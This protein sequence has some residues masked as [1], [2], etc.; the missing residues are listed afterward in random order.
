[1]QEADERKKIEIKCFSS[2]YFL[3]TDIYVCVQLF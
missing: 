3:I 2:F 1:M